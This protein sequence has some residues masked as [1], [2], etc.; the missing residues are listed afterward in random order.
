LFVDTCGSLF[1]HPLLD[2]GSPAGELAKALDADFADHRLS[3]ASLA[4]KQ[5]YVEKASDLPCRYASIVL[6]AR[7]DT[8]LNLQL[9]RELLSILP[10]GKILYVLLPG[11]YSQQPFSLLPVDNTSLASSEAGSVL[12]F[13]RPRGSLAAEEPLVCYS[14]PVNCSSLDLCAGPGVFSAGS[15]DKGT[16]AL[17]KVVK[18]QGRK[19]LD[20]GC[21]NGAIGLYAATQGFSEVTMV[22][23][24][25]RAL[26]HARENALRNDLQVD[27]VPIRTL[28]GLDSHSYDLVLSN[29]PYHSDYSVAKEFIE[30][31]YRGLADGGTMW[32]VVKN[33]AW[34]KNKMH[35]VFGGARVIAEGDYHIV[36]AEKRVT[37][38]VRGKQP[39]TTRKHARKMARGTRTRN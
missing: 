34:Y 36:M 32:L 5:L 11:G 28:K 8:A 7:F 3:N 13:V 30:E 31:G 39:K 14:L 38:T 10:V 12:R 15:L 2:Y 26:R 1:E 37:V 9:T 22:D 27:I 33:P 19:V 24:D 16:E 21:G 6:T 23:V 4:G 35:G 20:L 25:L 17:L 29:P 18:W